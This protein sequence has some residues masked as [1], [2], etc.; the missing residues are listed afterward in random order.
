[1]TYL[2]W[3]VVGVTVHVYLTATLCRKM[4]LMM[5]TGLAVITALYEEW[6]SARAYRVYWSS[7]IF[8]NTTYPALKRTW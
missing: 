1:M 8:S 6:P 5:S 4:S 7:V 3:I 2:S